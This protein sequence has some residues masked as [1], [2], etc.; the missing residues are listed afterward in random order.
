MELSC[1]LASILCLLNFLKMAQNCDVSTVTP[2]VKTIKK[3][4]R[5]NLAANWRDETYKDVSQLANYWILTERAQV[6]SEKAV[7]AHYHASLASQASHQN[8][9]N[10]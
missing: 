7:R 10:E 3:R 4:N 1:H 8:D 9:E 2:G 5:D 6:I